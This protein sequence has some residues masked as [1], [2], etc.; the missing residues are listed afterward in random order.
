M[1]TMA[2][3]K[4][5]ADA[6]GYFLGYIWWVLEPLLFVG[7]FY[8]VFEVL[9]KTGRGDFLIFLMCGK[10]AFIW[11]SKSVNQAANS[12]LVNRG[13]IANIN[14][15][16]ALFPMA[17]M[18]EGLYKQST[19]F[20]LL[21][22]ILFVRGYAPSLTWMWLLPLVLVNY[23]MILACGFISS[24]LVCVVRDFS[25]V[26]SLFMTF[27]MFVSGVFWDV[28]TLPDPQVA[29]RVLAVNPLAFILDAYRQILLHNTAPDGLHLLL[30]G[31]AFAAL[32]A[33]TALG[34]QRSSQYLAL[35]ALT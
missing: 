31:L 27:L 18:H 15:P 3:M 24:I 9:L 23:I 29:D 11:F 30:V 25:L 6:S 26:I 1:D 19:V 8:V 22:V 20:M 13:L 7:V 10:L 14:V 17:V 28:R 2:Q 16:K 4:L 12:I 34:M 35:K 5:R 33:V 21:F 32:L